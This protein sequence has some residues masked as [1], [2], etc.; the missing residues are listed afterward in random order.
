MFLREDNIAQGAIKINLLVDKLYIFAL[1]ADR[2]MC[3]GACRVLK[4]DYIIS[5]AFLR[6][7][8][9]GACRVLK[10]DYIE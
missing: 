3:A 7:S 5:N 4:G 8:M 2:M 9:A 10:G 6:I 1:G